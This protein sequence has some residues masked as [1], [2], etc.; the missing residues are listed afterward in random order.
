[1]AAAKGSIVNF[2]ELPENPGKEFLKRTFFF[3]SDSSDILEFSRKATEGA[4]TGVEKGVKLFY[5]VRDGIRY[6]PY[7]ILV[8]R[9]EFQASRIL[10]SS[11]AYCV[12]KAIVLAAAARA[13]GVPSAIGF[14]D[15][16]NHLNSEK[17]RAAM[18]TDIFHYHGY[19][20]L[21][22]DGKW[23]RVTPAF[24]IELCKKFGV[25]PLEFDGTR[26]ALLHPYDGAGRKHMEYLKYHGHF[27]DFPYER[28]MSSFAEFYPGMI[29]HAAAQKN[30]NANA[31]H[32]EDEA[33]L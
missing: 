32:F 27:T 16:R 24:N 6:D 4:K 23:R 28:V 20:A 21:F 17:L 19:T 31:A 14:A 12:P 13:V 26:D 30:K 8:K 25:L 29:E 9:E 18:G 10:Q 7:R 2:I 5:A 1:M 3:D 11:S 15:V 22:V 33:L